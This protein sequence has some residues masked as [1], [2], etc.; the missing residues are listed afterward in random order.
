MVGFIIDFL[1]LGWYVLRMAVITVTLVAWT[2]AWQ[3]SNSCFQSVCPAE[4]NKRELEIPQFDFARHGRVF[5][6]LAELGPCD[7]K[8]AW[9]F[10]GRHTMGLRPED[11]NILMELIQREAHVEEMLDK[12]RIRFQKY[13]DQELE[14]DDQYWRNFAQK[15]SHEINKL[16]EDKLTFILMQMIERKNDK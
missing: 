14:N 10:L 7:W 13:T 1:I 6:K 4:S 11:S 2:C 5:T 12:L 8:K 3:S 16:R 15:R 9:P